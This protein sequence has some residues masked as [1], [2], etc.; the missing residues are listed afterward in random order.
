MQGGGQTA[1]GNRQVLQRLTDKIQHNNKEDFLHVGRCFSI[2]H[3]D[4]QFSCFTDFRASLISGFSDFRSPVS[5]PG[6][7]YEFDIFNYRLKTL[8]LLLSDNP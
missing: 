7:I 8:I 1:G 6:T 2:S 3:Q 5:D 4:H